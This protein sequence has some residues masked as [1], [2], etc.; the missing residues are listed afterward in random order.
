VPINFVPERGRILMCDY[1]VARIP[2]EMDK[3]RRVVVVSPRSYNQ[4]HGS[5]PGRCLVVPFTATDPGALLRPA[6]VHFKNGT[7]RS[8]TVDT[9]AICSAAMAVSHARLDRVLINK[10]YASEMLSLADMHRVEK[11]LRHA[12]GFPIIP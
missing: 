7:Y 2:P 5:G 12:F 3:V 1:R 4:R 10:Q 9:W 8:L 6:D 11:G